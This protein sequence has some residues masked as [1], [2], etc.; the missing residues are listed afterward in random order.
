MDPLS[1]LPL[2]SSQPQDLLD[3]IY[4]DAKREGSRDRTDRITREYDA[5]IKTEALPVDRF[6]GKLPE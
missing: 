5:R 4:A 1:S 2:A 3:D 6:H